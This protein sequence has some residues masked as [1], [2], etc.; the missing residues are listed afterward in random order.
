MRAAAVLPLAI[1]VAACDAS[2]VLPATGE[3]AAPDSAE[4]AAWSAVLREHIATPKQ[5]MPVLIDSTWAIP[6]PLDEADH[7][8]RERLRDSFPPA[9]ALLSR[10][11]AVNG[12]SHA[13]RPA[14]RLDRE[15]RLLPLSE[16]K[17]F[18]GLPSDG[19]WQDVRDPEAGW[20]RFAARFPRADGVIRLSRV[21]FSTDG[22]WA[23]MYYDVQCGLTCGGGSYLGLR[24]DGDT[25]RVVA[26]VNLWAS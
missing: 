14:F 15:Y 21:A 5:R 9:E 19:A 6:R 1:M 24:R 12:R 20:E 22:D 13:M 23:L 8:G 17:A 10:F 3:V 25:W 26:D 2:R 7:Y 11:D 16:M 4:Y 18:F